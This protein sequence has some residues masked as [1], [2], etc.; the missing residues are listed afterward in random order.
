VEHRIFI[1]LIFF[2]KIR[3]FLK[4]CISEIDPSPHSP[5]PYLSQIRQRSPGLPA[6]IRRTVMIMV[7]NPGGVPG[8]VNIE[9]LELVRAHI[10]SN[11]AISEQGGE[12]Y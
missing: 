12:M 6:I 5:D 4:I 7:V 2:R 8:H 11:S 1:I 3:I 10:P 9:D